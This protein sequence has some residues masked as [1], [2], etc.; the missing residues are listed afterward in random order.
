MNKTCNNAAEFMERRVSTKG[1]NQQYDRSQTQSWD[2]ATSRL[3]VVRNA[4]MKDKKQ[5]FT[6]LFHHI[7][8]FLG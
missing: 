4:A 6:N 7:D 5:Q 3:L 8:V 2:D 1:N